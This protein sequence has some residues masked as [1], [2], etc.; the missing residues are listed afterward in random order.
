M[1]KKLLLNSVTS[2]V[3]QIVYIIYG[4]V[5][6]RLI[7][8]TYGSEVNG[9]ISSLN[10]F[11]SVI[12]LSEFGMTAVVQSSLYK[13]LS[14][15]DNLGISQVLTS[16]S[17]FFRKIG[18][19]YIVYVVIL[20]V[21]Y[22]LVVSTAFHEIYIA[23]MILILCMASLFQYLVG[24]SYLQLLIADQHAYV[25]Q[26]ANTVSILISILACVLLTKWQCSVHLLKLVLSILLLISPVYSIIYVKLKFR[27]VNT[28]T[29]YDSE[30]IKQKWNSIAHH[31]SAYVYSST[32]ILVL[33]VFSTLS[34]VSVYTVYNLVLNGL[35][36][37]CAMFDNAVKPI[38]G[39]LWATG[40]V[41]KFTK[42]FRLYEWGIHNLSVL[43]FGCATV[44]I[45]PFVKIYTTAINDRNIYI[46][47]AFAFLLSLA[48]MLQ[49]IKNI[50]HNL[51]Q[52]I[53]F[54]KQTQ[55]CYLITA[56]I[57]VAISIILVKKYGLIGVAIG[58][59]VAVWYQIIWLISFISGEILTDDMKYIKLIVLD[60]TNFAVPYFLCRRITEE[61]TSISS[62]I[63][64]AAFSLILWVSV[65][66]VLNWL[67]YRDY[68]REAIEMMK[69]KSK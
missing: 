12:A 1:K 38:L 15:N 19:V 20:C 8:S 18:L 35:Q 39:Q 55:N 48:V 24:L 41:K 54:F 37:L 57:N 6:P 63:M 33:S 56:I 34:N 52:S 59:L 43:I 3:Y 11:L 25:Y 30:P 58:T 7:L 40:E 5:A 47:P 29:G 14:R 26:I 49:N 28:H 17:R 32:D 66:S 65:M 10:Q 27:G 53:G 67:L 42:C 60:A 21:T 22:P 69:S 61:A 51:I 50:Y 31:L 64:C 36:K 44:L 68:I 2:L 23:K 9:L 16:S 4:F 45:V 62:W 13:P 46:V